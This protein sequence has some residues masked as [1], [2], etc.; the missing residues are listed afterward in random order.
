MKKTTY[1]SRTRKDQRRDSRG[2]FVKSC[3][4]CGG[5]G[6]ITTRRFGNAGMYEVFK[7]CPMCNGSGN[8]RD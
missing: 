4:Y 6:E 8:H 7:A 2:R 1:N 5:E 3:E